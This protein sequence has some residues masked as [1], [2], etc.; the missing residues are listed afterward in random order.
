MQVCNF[1]L[2]ARVLQILWV[3][4]KTW[5]TWETTRTGSLNSFLPSCLY[6]KQ[7]C[8]LRLV[9]AW[10][11]TKQKKT[12]TQLCCHVNG[13]NYKLQLTQGGS[14]YIRP[15]HVPCVHARAFTPIVFNCLSLVKIIN[16]CVQVWRG[17]KPWW[18]WPQIPREA[19]AIR[20]VPHLSVPP[21]A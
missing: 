3:P 19:S 20:M 6:Y 16:Y 2:L 21:S 15:S 8:C 1:F 9:Y 18:W 13:N 10:K 7:C 4:K 11:A 12:K 5:T 17:E 14:S